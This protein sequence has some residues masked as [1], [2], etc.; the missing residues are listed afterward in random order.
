MNP[1]AQWS[2]PRYSP[3]SE[4]GWDPK[5]HPRDTF[6]HRSR[7]GLALEAFPALLTLRRV[8]PFN[9]GN[10]LES[11]QPVNLRV[12]GLVHHAHGAATQLP[13]EFVAAKVLHRET[14]S[15]GA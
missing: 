6:G 2:A 8:E 12:A 3:R 13:Q 15:A 11:D 4:P 5:Y 9:R 10:D 14:P 1:P 7:A